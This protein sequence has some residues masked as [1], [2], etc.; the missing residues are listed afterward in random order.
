[1]Y[2]FYIYHIYITIYIIL[3]K[4]PA[5]P[6]KSLAYCVLGNPPFVQARA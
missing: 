5:Y 2:N 6:L 4:K 3:F 1:M